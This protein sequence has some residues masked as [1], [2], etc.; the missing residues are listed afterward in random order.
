MEKT[1]RCKQIDALR[2][3]LH[4]V[5]KFTFYGQIPILGTTLH[6]VDKLTIWLFSA[7]YY[8]DILPLE[9]QVCGHFKDFL[10]SGCLCHFFP[11]SLLKDHDIKRYIIYYKTFFFGGI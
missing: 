3:N 9:N 6:S 10:M 1:A 11:I 2:S 5:D 4:S 7:R 8:V